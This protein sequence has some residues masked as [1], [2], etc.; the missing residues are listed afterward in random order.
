MLNMLKL[1]R[2]DGNVLERLERVEKKLHEHAI[3]LTQVQMML[4]QAVE[5][6]EHHETPVPTKLASYVTALKAKL[7]IA[8]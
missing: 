2:I 8:T 4:V 5:H 1:D 6:M 7:D 3:E